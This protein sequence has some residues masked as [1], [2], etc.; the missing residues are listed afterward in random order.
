[1]KK[2]EKRQKIS[3]MHK[4]AQAVF[5][6]SLMFVVF[7]S[8]INAESENLYIEC[9]ENTLKNEQIATCY[10]KFKNY[11]GY[12][13][14]FQGI[15][16]LSNNIS[17]TA[18]TKDSI[19]EG[20]TNGGDIDLYTDINKTGNFNILSFSF[21]VPSS[22]NQIEVTLDEIA[23]SDENFVGIDIPKIVKTVNISNV[24]AGENPG[25]EDPIDNP[26]G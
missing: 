9:D 12:V 11:T 20:A 22:V 5:I 6:I 2:V 7:P 24:P 26:I 13:S 16:T 19:W 3:V 4:L 1:M 8:R 25:N 18:I 15:L 14:S 21:R 17:F 23:V 10:V